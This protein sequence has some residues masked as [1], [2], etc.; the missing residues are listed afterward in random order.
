MLKINDLIS[1]IIFSLLI[2]AAG[3][4]GNDVGISAVNSEHLDAPKNSGVND[5]VGSDGSEQHQITVE[6]LN[7]HY[8]TAG[9]G[10]S[11]VLIHGNAGDVKDFE[12]G[13]MSL[14]SRRYRL[15]AVDRP[16]HG[17]S[18]R[19]AEKA[20][21]V[22]FQAK[23]L[24]QTLSKLEILRPVL[25]GHSWG[26]SLALFYALEYPTDVAGLVL[27]APSAYPDDKSNSFLAGVIKI[28]VVGD[29][30][31][32][33]G[34]SILGRQELKH[35]LEQAFYPQKVPGEYY[36]SANSSWFGQKQLKAYLEDELSLNNSLKNM[37]GRYSSIK[38]PVVIVAGEEDKIVSPTENAYRLQ[39]AI[40]NSR[41]IKLKDTGHE[42]PLTNPKSIGKAIS[43]VYRR[44][45]AQ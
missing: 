28:P 39:K 45:S 5:S 26:A 37:A 34:K 40:P 27:L 12:F 17:G 16:G 15:I 36:E 31:I 24:H 6:N 23:L 42:I 1:V 8:I 18:D 43:W 9:S 4:G 11:V 7:V 3:F 29:L 21:T 25:V 32:M 35:T 14:L 10:R 33:L 30:S 38:I 20:D 13:T 44:V 22:E 19:P 41:L 2:A